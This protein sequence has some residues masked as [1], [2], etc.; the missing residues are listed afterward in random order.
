MSA[1]EASPKKKRKKVRRPPLTPEQ[2][3]QKKARAAY[4]K[5]PALQ[6]EHHK[7]FFAQ[8]AIICGMCGYPMDYEGHVLTDWEKKWSIHEPCKIKVGNMLDRETGI[9]RERNQK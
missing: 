3:A 9:A 8:P 7:A 2:K 5:D 1:D 4:F 6:D